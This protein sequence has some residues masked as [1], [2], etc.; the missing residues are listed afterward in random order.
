MLPINSLKKGM[1][2]IH[3]G[4][5]HRVVEHQHVK[6]GK[7][8]A[9]VRTKLKRLDSGAVIDYTFRSSEKV[10]QAVVSS[11]SMEYIYRDGDVLYFMD[12]ATYD[13]V[14]VSLDIVGEGAGYLPENCEVSF[15]MHGDTIVGVELPDTVEV[16]VDKT[17]P[18]FKG[19]TAQGGTKPATTSTGMVVHVPLFLEQGERIIVN[20]KTGKYLK[21]A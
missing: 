9:F 15:V 13:Q 6:P 17:D 16:T 4:A 3:N 5:L 14:P 18:G 2:I 7:G 12:K 21:R 11:K 8:P 10:E 19:D 20:I 1:T